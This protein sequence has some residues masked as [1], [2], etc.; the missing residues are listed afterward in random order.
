MTLLPKSYGGSEAHPSQC[1]STHMRSLPQVCETQDGGW[2]GTEGTPDLTRSLAGAAHWREPA[3]A[4]WSRVPTATGGVP[5]TREGCGALHARWNRPLRA[6]RGAGSCV[7]AGA[8]RRESPR[9][10]KKREPP[11]WVP[12]RGPAGQVHFTKNIIVMVCAFGLQ[13]N[14]SFILSLSF[15]F[16]FLGQNSRSSSLNLRA[17]CTSELN[18]S[19]FQRIIGS[20]LEGAR[21]VTLYRSFI[22]LVKG[23]YNCTQFLNGGKVVGS[24]LSSSNISNLHN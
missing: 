18:S 6:L 8:L 13:D 7:Y 23:K 20:Q 17:I 11:A 16:Y 4:T 9:K 1:F 24:D 22:C 15:H 2:G 21:G 14:T 12:V 5:R 3:D 10:R 19:L